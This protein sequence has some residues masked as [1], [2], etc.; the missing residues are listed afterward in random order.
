M[1]HFVF[2]GPP[3]TGKTTVARVCAQILHGL[4][5]IGVKKVVETSGLYLQGQCLG[6]TKK[7]VEEKLGEAKGGIL[8]IDEAYSLGEGY[9]GAEA[10]TTLV[11][12]MTDPA[13]REL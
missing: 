9:Y 10:M 2:R 11:E 3:G 12:A 1:G 4:G 8:F 7:C 5:I 13:T 6:Q